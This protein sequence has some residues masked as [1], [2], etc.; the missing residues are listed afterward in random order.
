MC[1]FNGSA[2]HITLKSVRDVNEVIGWMIDA[3]LSVSPNGYLCVDEYR[4]EARDDL[5]KLINRPLTHAELLREVEDFDVWDSGE[6]GTD[7]SCRY[8]FAGRVAT[9]HLRGKPRKEW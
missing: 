9:Y 3:Q 5:R 1:A 7:G 8:H 6:D 2:T 4:K